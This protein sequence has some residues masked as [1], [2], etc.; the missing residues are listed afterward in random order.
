MATGGM[1]LALDWDE[2]PDERLAAF[3]LSEKQNPI[4]DVYWIPFKNYV[5]HGGR[6]ADISN[7]LGRDW[8]PRL[9]R[10]DQSK[11]PVIVW[12]KVAHTFPNINTHSWIF[13]ERGHILHDRQLEQIRKT[14]EERRKVIDPQANSTELDSGTNTPVISLMEEQ[15]QIT[16]KGGTMRLG[17]YPCKLDPKSTSRRLYGAALVHERHRHRYEFNNDYREPLEKAGMRLAGI[18]PEGNLVE[19]IEMDKH[20]FFIATQFHPEF[21]SRPDR[22]HPLFDGFIAAA[23]AHSKK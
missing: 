7:I 3:I 1:V 12:P 22:P 21:K 11:P 20:P 19:I 9:W 5:R 14:S 18:W 2:L 15:S 6:K 13:L 4:Y 23:K 10:N 16:E 17:N 8:H